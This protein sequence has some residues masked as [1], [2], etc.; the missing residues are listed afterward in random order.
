[1]P[2]R[3]DLAREPSFTL[4]L[5]EVRPSNREVQAGAA[6]ETLEPRVMQVLVALARRRDEV[7][8]RDDLIAGCWSGR[9]VG[10]DAINR[11]IA[12]L[13]RL[14]ETYGGFSLETIARVGYRLTETASEAAPLPAA[15]G[16]AGVRRDVLAIVVL[17]LLGVTFGLGAWMLSPAPQKVLM[18]RPPGKL[19][20]AVLPFTP[21]YAD[22]DAQHLG[23]SIAFA[24][25]DML[26]GSAFDVVSPTK[27]L[28][29]RGSAKAGALQALHSDFVI[30]GDIRRENDKLDVAMRIIDGHSGT[31]VV[32]GN[33]E[34]ASSEADS[35]PDQIAERM[36]G[37]ATITRGLNP[38][39]GGDARVMSAYFRAIYQYG[40]HNDLYAANETAR[41]AVRTAPDDAFAQ[42]LHGFMAAYL[43]AAVPPEKRPA[44]VAEAREAAYR[45]IALDPG[46]G[47]SYAVLALTVP[48]FEWQT[49]ER[50]L[51]QG[52]AVFPDSQILQIQQIELL[53]NAG[54]FRDSSP[55]AEAMFS[56]GGSQTHQFVEVINARLWQEQE[57]RTLIARAR[58]QY[59]KV[60]WF[61]AKM[62]EAAAFH[63]AP[64]DAEALLQDPALAALL[65]PDGRPTFAR[66]AQA[67]RY[68]RAADVQAV[69]DD[70]ARPDG[71][72]PEVKRTCFM[73]LVALA[74]LDDAFRLADI[75]YPDQRGATPAER[76][77]KW[78][79]SNPIPAAYLSVP[80][81]APLRADPRYREVVERIGL[82]QYWKASHH[83]PDFCATEAVPV[84]RLVNS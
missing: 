78:F 61:A 34:F 13:R 42:A 7:V 60:P 17:I 6:R 52:L 46:Y 28:Q 84:C 20:I 2:E 18:V 68:R 75:V 21:L 14:S 19:S 24:V 71:R 44:M 73:A 22:A 79:T 29:Y 59:P 1:M 41:G 76:Q 33:F 12:R 62:F 39:Y 37:L 49:R 23:D 43:A 55:L 25:S 83:P 66:I 53:Q 9:V 64:G 4:G 81:T 32:A 80:V 63:G 27:T 38:V 15:R 26:T 65:E 11:C 31:T 30:D 67:L 57:T 47:N 3:I 50:Y 16:W 58:T 77:R 74:R 69:V 51:H 5:L 72:S 70:C 45:A 48:L 56:R 40:F 10:D 35:A 8:S 36:N 82:L 54:R